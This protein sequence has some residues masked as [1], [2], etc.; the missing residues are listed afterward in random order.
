MEPFTEAFVIP[1]SVLG[2]RDVVVVEGPDALSYLQSQVS[3]ELRDLQVGGSTWTLVLEPT[4][5]V[6]SLARVARTADERF[7]LDTDAG[8]GAD[9]L[10]RL[11]R[12]K[13]RVKATTALIEASVDAP[14]RNESERI[15]LGWP[16]MGH[17]LVAGETVP[18]GTGLT[19]IA[20]NFT[21]GCYPGQELV[22]RMDSRGA[23]APRTL[24]RLDVP[25]G[26]A[27]G[28][29]VH[30]GDQVVGEITSVVLTRA[31]GWVKRSS[32]IGEAVQF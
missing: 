23:E 2:P 26:S 7:E 27:A 32:G 12:F 4:G 16:A 15:E 28:D 8:Y 9:L 21:K 11:D 14:P 24:R 22:E 17:E 18:Q 1:D 19:R 10:A 13:I 25:E 31:L 6:T 3:Q 5:K 30:D 20:V 29:P